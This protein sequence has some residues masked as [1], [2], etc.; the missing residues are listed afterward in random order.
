MR[1]VPVEEDNFVAALEWG[2]QH[3]A[4]MASSSLGYKDWWSFANYDGKHSPASI[5]IAKAAQR[6]MPVV[7]A[8]GNYGTVRFL[9][10]RLFFL[11]LLQFD[12]AC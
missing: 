1:E 3:G 4:D 8:V 12:N 11:S 6:G 7:V 9:L 5:A 2:E 10:M